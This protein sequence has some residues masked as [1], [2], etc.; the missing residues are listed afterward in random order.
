MESLVTWKALDL[1]TVSLDLGRGVI[2][3]NRCSGG[4]RKVPHVESSGQFEPRLWRLWR[5]HPS[6]GRMNSLIRL[7]SWTALRLK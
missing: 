4:K 1:Y 7:T 3:P 5:G 6:F 2:F